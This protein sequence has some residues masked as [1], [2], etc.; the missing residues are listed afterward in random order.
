MHNI[1]LIPGMRSGLAGFSQTTYPPL[2]H[3]WIAL[4]S[5]YV[6]LTEAFMLVQLTP[7]S[8]GGWHLALRQLWVDE[9]AASLAALL[10]VF[11]GSLHFLSTRQGSCPP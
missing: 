4:L 2:T 9:R 8:S 7:S 10:A 11:A 3:Q 5:Q 1:G 6:G